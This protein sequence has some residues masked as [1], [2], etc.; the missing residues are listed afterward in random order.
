MDIVDTR[1]KPCSSCVIF[2]PSEAGKTELVLPIFHS[3]RQEC[4]FGQKIDKIF[5]IYSIWQKAYDRLKQQNPDIKF[6]ESFSK[7][8]SDLK[9][10]HI[11]VWDDMFLT[12]QTNK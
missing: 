10:I 1:I 7:V 6:I 9:E 5:Y 2:G 3:D 8:P 4:V 12:F 11:V